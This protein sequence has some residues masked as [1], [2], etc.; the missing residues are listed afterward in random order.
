[1]KVGFPRYSFKVLSLKIVS[2]GPHTKLTNPRKNPKIVTVTSKKSRQNKGDKISKAKAK[3][4][5]VL[6]RK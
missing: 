1:L 4:K 5:S 2:L 6:K 3:K